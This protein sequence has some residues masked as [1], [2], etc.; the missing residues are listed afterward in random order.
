MKKI[1]LISDYTSPFMRTGPGRALDGELK[2]DLDKKNG[3]FF[4]RLHRFLTQ[5]SKYDIIVELTLL[6]N[7]YSPGVWALNPLNAANNINDLEVFKWPDY[8]LMRHPKSF[9]RQA[10]HVKKIVRRQTSMTM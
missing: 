5:A 3:E 8:I 9:Q 4:D 6:S 1:C 2:Y 7:T 10:T